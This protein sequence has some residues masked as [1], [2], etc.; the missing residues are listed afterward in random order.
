MSMKPKQNGGCNDLLFSG[1]FTNI[2]N[3]CLL[4][5][6]VYG[7]YCN[8]NGN[9]NNKWLLKFTMLYLWTSAVFAAIDMIATRNH[10]TVDVLVALIFTWLFWKYLSYPDSY[11][12]IELK[13]YSDQFKKEFNKSFISWVYNKFNI[14][15]IDKERI[16]LSI[17]LFIIVF[18]VFG[19]LLP[20]S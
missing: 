16:F 9:K 1:H 11:L 13:L 10:Y 3:V 20:G 4:F 15:S 14:D 6:D 18:T 8:Y 19:V 7:K 17:F 5:N 2:M 12:Y